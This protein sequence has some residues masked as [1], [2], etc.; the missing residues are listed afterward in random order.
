[1][2]IDIGTI[3]SEPGLSVRPKLPFMQSP[4]K[5]ITRSVT[6]R[7]KRADGMSGIGDIDNSNVDR[8]TSAD[9]TITATMLIKYYQHK[10]MIDSLR[11]KQLTTFRSRLHTL[12]NSSEIDVNN[13]AET[14]KI[15]RVLPGFYEN[16]VIEDRLAFFSA[17]RKHDSATRNHTLTFIESLELRQAR[18]F[19]LKCWF[20][21]DDKHVYSMA[22]PVSNT[23]ITLF[24]KELTK[25]QVHFDFLGLMPSPEH[26]TKISRIVNWRF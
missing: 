4:S 23:L 12:L 2:T 6:M 3:L 20:Q 1:M 18:V 9:D 16:D 22:V 5:L 7:R 11:G 25:K 17:P 19:S 15:I 21:D 13:D 14:T 8:Y 26:S 24:R 10:I